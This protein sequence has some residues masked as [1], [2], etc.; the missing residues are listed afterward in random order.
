MRL[1]Q[2]LFLAGVTTVVGTVLVL[3]WALRRL[4]R[5]VTAR[6]EALLHRPGGAWLDQS[7]LVGLRARVPGDGQQVAVVRRDLQSDLRGALRAVD[8]G[9]RSGRP[10]GSLERLAVRLTAQVRE[11]DTDL[12]VVASETDRHRRRQLLAQQH[13]RVAAVRAACN[14]VREGVLLAGTSAHTPLTEEIAEEVLRL[15]LR[16]GA[17]QELTGSP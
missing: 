12:A 15:R 8:A 2:W 14:Q 5:A 13:Q 6:V 7:A 3:H 16:A 1:L 9:K 11:L 17:Y 10:V 4:R